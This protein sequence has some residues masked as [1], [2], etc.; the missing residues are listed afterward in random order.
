[1]WETE[2][3]EEEAALGIIGRRILCHLLS[4]QNSKFLSRTS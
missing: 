1:M 4:W 2:H 3:L